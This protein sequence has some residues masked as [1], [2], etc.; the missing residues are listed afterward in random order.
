M[1]ITDENRR[2]T[3]RKKERR[4]AFVEINNRTERGE[5]A[6]REMGEAERAE[7]E[8]TDRAQERTNMTERANETAGTNRTAGT[9]A[10][11]SNGTRI[12]SNRTWINASRMNSDAPRINVDSDVTGVTDYSNE[13]LLHYRRE[14]NKYMPSPNYMNFQEEIRWAMRTVLVDWIIDVHFKLN[15]LPETLYLSVNLID[16]FLSLRIVTIGKLQLVGVSGLLIASK[17]QEIASPSVETFV[18]ITDRSFTVNEI[19]RAEKYMLH[20]L[21][22]RIN[23]PSPLNWLRKYSENKE[24]ERLGCIIMD[25][26]LSQE[27]FLKYTP[28]TIGHS[29]SYLANQLVGCTNYEISEIKECTEEIKDHLRKPIVQGSIF[30]KYGTGF[31]KYLETL[32]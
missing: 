20:C 7:D 24:A 8:R 28:S 16:R 19:L 4:R 1:R 22:Y 6:E 23:Y 10:S 15:L 3:Q 9:N 12:N 26:I 2:E 30:K 11:H 32:Q 29:A 25:T 17:F 31:T 14:E 18:V 21:D 13:I 27:R 5:R